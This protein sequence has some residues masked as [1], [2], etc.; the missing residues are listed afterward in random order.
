M[1]SL[2][3]EE[4]GFRP[5]AR[6]ITR[7]RQAMKPDRSEGFMDGDGRVH[8]LDRRRR[9]SASRRLA[10]G[11]PERS[12]GIRRADRRDAS[13]HA[14]RPR[15]QPPC[16][17]RSDPK[18]SSKRQSR[19]SNLSKVLDSKV[20][21]SELRKR[22]FTPPTGKGGRPFPRT[23]RRGWPSSPT[24]PAPRQGRTPNLGTPF[25]RHRDRCT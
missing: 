2:L 10:S 19:G 14:Y 17:L 9:A 5:T 12:G 23:S 6:R 8:P 11:W 4:G 16:G 18:L 15:A 1:N 22:G 20:G 13:R 7:Q 25:R 21:C 3:I 24:T